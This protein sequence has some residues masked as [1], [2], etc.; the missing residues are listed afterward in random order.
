MTEADRELA[1]YV[2]EWAGGP[3]D[4]TLDTV[5]ESDA[6]A[7]RALV[8]MHNEHW[9]GMHRADD[10]TWVAESW[11]TEPVHTREHVGQTPH[12]AIFMAHRSIFGGADVELG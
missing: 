7:F 5:L 3:A 9:A 6:L 12:I 10:G 8:E 2:Y 1:I 11:H 4:E